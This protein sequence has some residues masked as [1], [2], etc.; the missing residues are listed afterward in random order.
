MLLDVEKTPLECI[1]LAQ[2]WTV[3]LIDFSH[4]DAFLLSLSEDGFLLL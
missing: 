3:A 1:S 4:M 2:P